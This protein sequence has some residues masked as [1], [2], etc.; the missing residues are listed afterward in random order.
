MNGSRGIASTSTAALLL[1]CSGYDAT[2]NSS[3]SGR[4][5]VSAET[6]QA[7]VTQGLASYRPVGAK[8]MIIGNMTNALVGNARL[9]ISII[10]AQFTGVGPE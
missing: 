7:E 1:G 9:K 3:Q 5:P 2:S 8:L 6:R 4:E 10:S